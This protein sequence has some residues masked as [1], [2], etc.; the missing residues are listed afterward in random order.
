MTRHKP[1]SLV[2]SAAIVIVPLAI[3]SP[4][5]L[6]RNRHPRVAANLI[7]FRRKRMNVFGVH[8]WAL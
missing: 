5:K 2:P 3:G 4:S 8:F 7:Q 1:F 6:R